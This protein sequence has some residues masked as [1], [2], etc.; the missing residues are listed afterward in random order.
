MFIL[1]YNHAVKGL[2]VMAILIAKVIFD[3]GYF[4]CRL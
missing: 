2:L 1:R 4:P 3:Y